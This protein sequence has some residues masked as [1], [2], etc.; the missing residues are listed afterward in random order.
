MIDNVIQFNTAMEVLKRPSTDNRELYIKLLQEEVEEWL[1]EAYATKKSPDK[2]LK[3]LCDVMYIIIG[4]AHTQGWDL[5]TAF[6]R[7]HNSNMTKFDADGRPIFNEIGKL[8]KGPKYK[9]PELKDLV[10]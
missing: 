2:E 8:I 7:V 1:E 6:N 9:E 4:Y 10:Q 5:L 3:E